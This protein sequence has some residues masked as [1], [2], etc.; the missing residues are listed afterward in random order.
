MFS[1]EY[2]IKRIMKGNYIVFSRSLITSKFL[3]ILTVL[4][5]SMLL[6]MGVFS[7]NATAQQTEDAGQ[8]EKSGQWDIQRYLSGEAIAPLSPPISG[9]T[10]KRNV[11]PA[12][13]TANTGLAKALRNYLSQLE[14]TLGWGEYDTLDKLQYAWDFKTADVAQLKNDYEQLMAQHQLYLA[15]LDRVK[16]KL[17]KHG[18]GTAFIKVHND[19]KQAYLESIS[20]LLDLLNNLHQADSDIGMLNIYD[21]ASIAETLK[22]LVGEQTPAILRAQTLPVRQVSRST[23]SPLKIPS[24][25]PSYQATLFSIAN[26]DDTA[27][28][29]DVLF[30]DTVRELAEQLEHN[31]AK[32]FE[33]LKNEITTQYYAGAMK[34][35]DNTLLQKSGNS[36][37]QSSALISLLRASNIPARYV[38]GVVEISAQQLQ[39]QLGINSESNIS[40]ALK[41]TGIAHKAI[42]RGGKIAAY[43]VEQTWVSA[44]IPYSN[45][46]GAV[47][48][49]SGQS[50][51]PLMPSIKPMNT[52]EPASVWATSSINGSEFKTSF[53]NSAQSQSPSE[54]LEQQLQIALAAAGS[55]DNIND[56]LGS[57]SIQTESIGYTPN[58]LPVD[59]IAVTSE[60]SELAS[61]KRH[62]VNFKVYANKESTSTTLI[63][64]TLPLSVLANQRITLSY[65][66]GSTD[67]Q[68][69]VNGF[70][71][72]G[73]VPAYLV[74]L[75]PQIKINGIAHAIGQDVMGMGDVHRIEIQSYGPG[76][77]DTVH[78]NVISGSY[79]AVGISA[80][81]IINNGDDKNNPADTEYQAARILSQLALRYLHAW[82]QADSK[83]AN[84]GNLAI[85]KPTPSIVFV[86]SI[87]EVERIL[88]QPQQLNWQGVEIDAVLRVSETIARNENSIAPL[89]WRQLSALNGSYLEHAILESDFGVLGISA[90]KVIAQAKSLGDAIYEINSTNI[91]TALLELNHSQA[92][93]DDISDWVSQGLNVTVSQ[94][95]VSIGAWQGAGWVVED[96]ITGAAGYFLSGGIAGGTSGTQPDGWPED[97]AS[98]LMEPYMGAQNTD[99]LSGAGVFILP[100][101]DNQQGEVDTDSDPLQVVVIDSAGRRVVG[102]TVI[103]SVTDGGGSFENDTSTITV[104]TNTQGIAETTVTYPKSTHIHRLYTKLDESDEYLTQVGGVFV[105]VAVVSSS[106]GVLRPSQAFSLLAIPSAAVS[107]FNDFTGTE[108][109]K[110]FYSVE[111]L[112]ESSVNLI[113]LDQYENPVSNAEFSVSFTE[114]EGLRSY[115]IIEPGRVMGPEQQ[116]A[117]SSRF[118]PYSCG[119]ASVS[120]K[121]QPYGTPVTM[122]MGRSAPE[123]TN[124][125]TGITSTFKFEASMNGVT[126]SFEHEAG[127]VLT[128]AAFL[129]NK[130]VDGLQSAAN[131]GEVYAAPIPVAVYYDPA[132]IQTPSVEFEASTIGA[133][134]QVGGVTSVSAVNINSVGMLE[135]DVRLRVS[136]D[137]I[138]NGL[139]VKLGRTTL[140]GDDLGTVG[141]TSAVVV[142]VDL[143][144]DPIEPIVA[145]LDGKIKNN[146]KVTFQYQP[147]LFWPTERWIEI[148]EDD[149]PFYVGPTTLFEGGGGTA[150]IPRSLTFDIFKTYT[151]KIKFLSGGLDVASLLESA[152]VTLVLDIPLLANV[153]GSVD[154]PSG[155]D[156][157]PDNLIKFQSKRISA[158]ERYDLAN[159]TACRGI[160]KLKFLLTSDATVTLE[161]FEEGANPLTD[162]ALY[163]VVNNTEFDQ[164]ENLINDVFNGVAPGEYLFRITA[165]NDLRTESEIGF[166]VFRQEFTNPLSIGHSN[167]ENIDTFQGSLFLSRTD[168]SL[169]DRGMPINLIRSY[170]SSNVKRYS[171]GIAWSH[172]YDS[173][174]VETGCGGYTVVGGDGSGQSFRAEGAGFVSQKGY[175]GTLK[176][177]D[178]GFDFYSTNGTRYHYARYS[179]GKNNEWYLQNIID[180]NGNTTSLAYDQLGGTHAIVTLVETANHKLHLEYKNIS[181]IDGYGPVLDVAYACIPGKS[182]TAGSDFLVKAQYLYD[183]FGRLSSAQYTGTADSNF[184]N[185]LTTRTEKY[186]YK[187]NGVEDYVDADGQAIPFVLKERAAISKITDSL[188]NVVTYESELRKMYIQAVLV[189]G[190]VTPPRLPAYT[191]ITK[192]EDGDTDIVYT[193]LTEALRQAASNNGNVTIDTDISNARGY[194][195]RFSHNGYGAPTKIVRALGTLEESTQEMFWDFTTDIQM[196]WT[197]DDNDYTTHFEHDVNGN[198][199]REYIEDVDGSEITSVY[200]VLGD[201]TIKNRLK[202]RTDRNGNTTTYA[203]DSRGNLK[204]IT[205][206]LVA[207][208]TSKVSNLAPQQYTEESAYNPNGDRSS[209][210]DRNGDMTNFY[211]DTYGNV[212]RVIKGVNGES[213]ESLTVWNAKGLKVSEENAREDVTEY[214]YDG[215]NNLGRIDYPITPAG[216]A[217]KVFTYDLNSNKLSETDEE[218]KTTSWEYDEQNRVEEHTNAKLKTRDFTY[219]DSGNLTTES[220]FRSGT[221]TTYIYNGLDQQISLTGPVDKTLTRTYDGVGNILS[222]YITDDRVTLYG[223]D[224]LYRQNSITVPTQPESRITTI[225]Y[226]GNGNRIQQTDGELNT[227][228]YTY[229]ELNRLVQQEE[230]Y[231]PHNAL[232]QFN[233]I[234]GFVYDGNG[235]AVKEIN[236]E[237]GITTRAYDELDRLI[238]EKDPVQNSLQASSFASSVPKTWLY[239]KAGNTLEVVNRRNFLTARTYDGRNRVLSVSV[240]DALVDGQAQIVPTGYE[241]DKVGN[242]TKET[243]PSGNIVSSH[244]DDLHLLTQKSDLVGDIISLNGYDDDNNLLTSEDANAH[245]TSYGYDLRNRQT[246][247]TLHD[248]RQTETTY[249][250]YG[251]IETTTDAKEYVT[252]YGYNEANEL[253]QVTDPGP[254][255]HTATYAYDQVGNK[256]LY[257]DRDRRG[258]DTV[259]DYDGFNRLIK[260]TLP[261]ALTEDITYDKN[262]NVKTITDRRDIVTENVYDENDRLISITRD[263]ILILRERQY[264]GEGNVLIETDAESNTSSFTY[265]ARNLL[266]RESHP[267]AAIVL[268]EYN[269]M[270][271]KTK[272]TD[273]EGRVSRSEYDLRSRIQFSYMPSSSG[274]GEDATEFV[275][276]GVNL[277]KTKILPKDNNWIYDHDVTNRL[278][279]IEQPG[280]VITRY[281]YDD[282]NNLETQTDAEENVT[283]FE[284]D[285]LNRKTLHQFHDLNTVTYDTY[286]E[287]GNLKQMTDANGQVVNFEYDTINRET[288]RTYSGTTGAALDAQIQTVTTQYDGN[289]NTVG[290]TEVYGG[291]LGPRTYRWTYDNFDR[292]SSYSDAFSLTVGYQYDLNGNRTVLTDPDGRVT[293]YTYDDLNRIDTVINIAGVTDYSYYRDSQIKTVTYPNSI[294]AHYQ[295]DAASRVK[296]I[297]NRQNNAIVSRFDYL[298]DANGNR[299]QQTEINGASPEVT[300]YQYDALDRLTDVYYNMA[301]C[302][303]SAEDLCAITTA[304]LHV[305]YGYDR[306]Y[307]RTSEVHTDSVGTIILDRT[308]VPNNRNQID[309]I[310]DNLDAT[311]HVDYSYDQNGNQLSKTTGSE[312]SEFVW[313]TRN[314]LRQVMQGGST[315]G[316]FL[317]DAQGLRVQKIGDRGTEQYTYDDQS[318]LVQKDEIGNTLAK[319]DYG[320]DRLLSLESTEG[321]QFYLFD[322]LKSVVNLAN[323]EGNIQARYQYDAFGNKRN[324]VGSSFN[325][326]SFTGYEEDTETGLLYA[327]ARFYD[328]DTGRFL[329]HDA[330]EGDVNTPPSLHKYLY[331]YQ[332]PTVYWDPDGNQTKL[333]AELAPYINSI[334]AHRKTFKAKNVANAAKYAKSAARAVP[335]LGNG[336]RALDA[337]DWVSKHPERQNQKEQAR[338]DQKNIQMFEQLETCGYRCSVP[339]SDE[340]F[341]A[342]R[343]I[344]NARKEMFRPHESGRLLGNQEFIL[345]LAKT[346]NSVTFTTESD[347]S[348]SNDNVDGIGTSSTVPDSA[349]NGANSVPLGPWYDSKATTP[350]GGGTWADYITRKGGGEASTSGPINHGHHIFLKKGRGKEGRAISEEGQ[351]ILRDTG[352]DPIIGLE[353]LTHAPLNGVGIH[354]RATQKEI[355]EGLRSLKAKEAPKQEYDDLLNQYG[356]KARNALVR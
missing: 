32:I 312:V 97:I 171:V 170:S 52:V 116:S 62:W 95:P 115:V 73:N 213:Y 237:D 37:D 261:E 88:T 204:L 334:N 168:I 228:T 28:S 337:I 8:S 50:W 328:P 342:S 14:T 131:T 281:T 235:N 7:M 341:E 51:L 124:I 294:S 254:S 344:D 135:Y 121:S 158:F 259:F 347:S 117:C 320:P 130:T 57:Q 283:R 177:S 253:I 248:L 58:S 313:D 163:T 27:S 5:T 113:A 178:N 354:T 227:T 103:F 71:G 111:G 291:T 139:I 78:K 192:P 245:T 22:T 302:P 142:G 243:L 48:D 326:F 13:T 240:H 340:Y 319:Y 4:C 56:L 307:N 180:T 314:N 272:A 275:Y 195:T 60:S 42:V 262:N 284:Y 219:D 339:G 140:D 292:N 230:Q 172:N 273:P 82:D 156:V 132:F 247:V 306:A 49:K 18:A 186:E 54:K 133:V 112:A 255:G 169:P 26:V 43:E 53:L 76:Y 105:D 244:Y 218:G 277:L 188:D 203:Y 217:F 41:I 212:N 316:Q 231:A 208:T 225:K 210:K 303:S 146:R 162:S 329:S 346:E 31:P 242:L 17:E 331:A 185:P 352:I 258:N 141:Y 114:A 268:Y 205:Y 198:V 238:E 194:T 191:K 24:I 295:Y 59:V 190:V 200:E 79:H 94:N 280:N 147:A 351:Q 296:N 257:A 127:A 164:G 311:A 118:F 77:A 285:E 274:A 271:Q 325:R 159:E 308:L 224:D 99:P 263:E 232:P 29:Q 353:N 201:G 36:V 206:P 197:K 338:L 309:N 23:I 193:E 184:E 333:A 189:G 246:H 92:V 215:F 330:W 278:T 2:V 100:E 299:D 21:L 256:V 85:F 123:D 65:L 287:N 216:D 104:L 120:F 229:D 332:N 101:S 91:A 1:L 61:D 9:S 70:G 154:A 321:T 89:E 16:S 335:G 234:I 304:N 290:I 148:T 155:T 300:R 293:R 355:L 269:T 297:E 108:P 356:E 69:I 98:Y 301:S 318:V 109:L 286:D 63:D 20:P 350:P 134:A 211:Y 144:L 74:D 236:G 126:Q 35:V 67:A 266:I 250:I 264:D 270:G 249:D 152:P 11:I 349:A 83:L 125:L 336:L 322:A 136:T 138:V 165:T 110:R 143:E 241:Y 161:L 72:L 345:E 3:G 181:T 34:G 252:T 39:M 298:Y 90:D 226:D 223:Y 267:E 202:S 220:G 149:A 279:Y 175:H 222:E 288:Q 137:P 196:K 317:Y 84:F 66:P 209:V 182:C 151:A 25:I 179:F 122:I 239:D 145:G 30:T 55:N 128:S 174:V 251:N 15:Y 324:Q 260:T 315:V 33:Y 160:G 265:D 343:T 310:I 75:R 12:K 45:Y 44:L 96:T 233:R 68:K 46:R 153:Q 6:S 323:R 106:N 47:V 157:L 38:H 348:P 282:N 166:A 150:V 221:T 80:Q 289:N 10:V 305:N 87:I 327:K 199:T 19:N 129:V 214:A 81:D 40:E 86:S 176:A 187:I 167:Y 207:T 173:K 183:D 64:T 93:K 107:I 102:A 119:V 276:D